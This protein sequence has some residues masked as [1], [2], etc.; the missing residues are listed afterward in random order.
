M[1]VLHRDTRP[2]K[3]IKTPSV[4]TQIVT[5]GELINL[6]ARAGSQVVE[7]QIRAKNADPKLGTKVKEERLRAVVEAQAVYEAL[8]EAERIVCERL[9]MKWTPP[10]DV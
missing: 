9:G 3:T 5:R 10:E 8:L 1:S 7:C 2:I 6:R 4:Y